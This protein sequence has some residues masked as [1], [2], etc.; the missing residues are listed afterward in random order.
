MTNKVHSTENVAR[1]EMT[2]TR[3]FKNKLKPQKKSE[4]TEHSGA[5]DESLQMEVLNLN[6]PLG[7]QNL[8]KDQKIVFA[9]SL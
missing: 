3:R 6:T 2:T 9:E 1:G 5:G 7:Y 8:H 4:V